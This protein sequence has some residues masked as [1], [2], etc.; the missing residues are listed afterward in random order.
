MG[1]YQTFVDKQKRLEQERIENEKKE[2]NKANYEKYKDRDY[3]KKSKEKNKIR[4]REWYWRNR[5]YVLEKN[6]QKK[7]YNSEYYKDW[8]QKNRSSNKPIGYKKSIYDNS[9]KPKSF[10]VSFG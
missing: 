9:N 7:L 5:E 4:A 2:I 1:Y 8:Y 3:F 10:I 6:K